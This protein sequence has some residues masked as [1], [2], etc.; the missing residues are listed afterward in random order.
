MERKDGIQIIVLLAAFFILL[1][2][3]TPASAGPIK[4]PHF[5]ERSREGYQC[6]TPNGSKRRCNRWNIDGEKRGFK[7]ACVRRGENI[8]PQIVQSHE[9]VVAPTPSRGCAMLYDDLL[10]DIRNYEDLNVDWT[11]PWNSP[12]FVHETYRPLRKAE[13]R[14][15]FKIRRGGMYR[16]KACMLSRHF[17]PLEYI[18][19]ESGL[20]VVLAEWRRNFEEI[21]HA[22]LPEKIEAAIPEI[23]GYVGPVD[24][25]RGHAGLTSAYFDGGYDAEIG[26][27]V[28]TCHEKD[29]R[30]GRGFY[31]VTGQA[32]PAERFDEELG[33]VSSYDGWG[34]I[35]EISLNRIKE[36]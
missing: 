7:R 24:G 6:T 2:W 27:A 1:F 30:L 8:L 19:V 28:W 14:Q 3:F 33:V 10:A 15:M 29:V 35:S 12:D 32:L 18:F 16:L 36:K 17:E 23:G 5:A 4:D 20:Q 21:I 31:V 26:E 34:G 9:D 22:T 25:Y 11:N 13:F